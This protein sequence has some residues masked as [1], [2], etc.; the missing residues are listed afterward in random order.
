MQWMSK[1]FTFNSLNLSQSESN[2][3]GSIWCSAWENP[4]LSTIQTG[5]FHFCFRRIVLIKVKY[6]QD[7]VQKKRQDII[8]AHLPHI[9][10]VNLLTLKIIHRQQLLLYCQWE[11]IVEPIPLLLINGIS[12]VAKI[13]IYRSWVNISY[14]LVSLICRGWNVS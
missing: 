7:P 4:F 13:T 11:L 5:N 2:R 9:I 12:H 10:L 6:K 1:C 8:A 3:R 14:S